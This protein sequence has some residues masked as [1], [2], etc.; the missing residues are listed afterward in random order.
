[1][2][3][4]GIC[5]LGMIPVRRQPAHASELI[6]QLI[7]G[8][9]FMVLEEKD[10]WA[11]IAGV[12][13]GYEGYITQSSFEP[14]STEEFNAVESSRYWVI[15]EPLVKIKNVNTSA[16]FY[17]PGGST[18][19]GFKEDDLTF[20]ILDNWFQFF[21]R[22]KLNNMRGG[23]DVTKIAFRYIHSPYLWGG[24]TALGIDC[25]GFTQIVYRML[26]I[27]L[28][29]DA[30]Q[31]VNKGTNINFLA[32]AKEGDLAFFD[33]EEGKII[34]VG[35]LLSNSEI[36]H[37]LGMVRVDAIDQTGIYD[38][39]KKKYTHKLRIIKRVLI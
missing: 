2:E 35:I 31:Q 30:S 27:A 8:D 6:N 32:E 33:D 29:R 10:G 23:G 5:Q 12:Y 36:I 9:P 34:H 39:D 13:D 21:D 16:S 15:C 25:S 14:F 24:R 18:I 22:P 7:F 26:N 38:R 1:M 3:K 28:P 4:Y 19:F 17:I 20:H 11:R 37:S